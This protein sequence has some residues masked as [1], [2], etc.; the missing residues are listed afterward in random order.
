M[1]AKISERE[2]ERRRHAQS[3]RYA[4]QRERG[5]VWRMCEHGGRNG[6]HDEADQDAFSAIN[7]A[8]EIAD[9]QARKGH[10]QRA[11]IDGKPHLRRRHAV[12]LGERG[13]DGLR[14]EQIDDGEEGGQRDDEEAEGGACG[15]MRL[16]VKGCDGVRRVVHGACSSRRKRV[17]VTSF[18]G[19]RASHP[20]GEGSYIVWSVGSFSRSA[21]SSTTVLSPRFFHQCEMPLVSATTSPALCAIGTAQLLAY[22]LISPSMM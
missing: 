21:E 22:S 11:G 20:R 12:M 6:E 19:R 8:T 10:T 5:E 18:G 9:G 17:D 4:Q 13:K 16:G 15:V 3:L 2:R 7:L 14:G 1:L